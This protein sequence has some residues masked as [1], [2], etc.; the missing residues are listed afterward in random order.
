MLVLKNSFI[1]Q[2]DLKIALSASFIS[3]SLSINQMFNDQHGDHKKA[4]Q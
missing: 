3:V 1:V 2:I 4:T